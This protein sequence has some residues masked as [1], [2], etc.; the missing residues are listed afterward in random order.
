MPIHYVAYGGLVVLGKVGAVVG[1]GV[2]AAHHLVA[3]HAVAAAAA[4]TA[5]VVTV[6][7]VDHKLL[8]D[9]YR[10]NPPP[11]KM[12]KTVKIAI[13]GKFVNGEFTTVID[14]EQ[15][16]AVLQGYMDEATQDVVKSRVLRARRLDSG[17]AESLVGG[18]ML[19]F[20]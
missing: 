20:N 8:T 15:P 14:N 16:T 7:Y 13:G 19:V 9:W 11:A 2:L 10:D 17:L 3:A 12:A 5:T 18:G 1:K 4:G 6:G